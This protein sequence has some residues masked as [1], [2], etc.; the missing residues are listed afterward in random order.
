MIGVAT[1]VGL[2]LLDIP[3]AFML[4]AVAGLISF[5]PTI[6]AVV[7][8][9]PAMLLAFQVGQQTVLYVLV[10]YL[11]IQLVESYASDS[12][13][14]AAGSFRTPSHPIGVPGVDGNPGGR[15]RR[16]DRHARDGTGH[17]TGASTVPAR[18]LRNAHGRE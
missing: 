2:W 5:V 17:R 12:L 16:C 4:G 3:M 7:A 11:A 9:L 13:G 8:I 14:T 18:R 15:N 10:L 6:G 1:G